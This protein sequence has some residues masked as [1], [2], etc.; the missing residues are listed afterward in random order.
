M[1]K[2]HLIAAFLI[3]AACTFKPEDDF[4]VKV[5]PNN[6][7]VTHFQFFDEDD[8]AMR[9]TVT[10]DFRGSSEDQIVGYKLFLN[11]TL[12]SE[13]EHPYIQT[14][15][16]RDFE[17]G[18]YTL[19][20]ILTKRSNSE[21][22]GSA[23]GLEFYE[24]KIIRE[25]TIYNAPIKAPEITFE[26]I[27]G[28]LHANVEPYTGHGFEEYVVRTSDTPNQSI[29]DQ[30]FQG[31]A[32]PD[33]VGGSISYSIWLHAYNEVV[34][35]TEYY[36]NT[37]NAQVI[38]TETGLKFTWN[39]SPFKNWNGVQIGILPQ[40]ASAYEM[41]TV[42]KS[43]TEFLIDM[44][45]VFPVNV[46]SYIS[47]QNTVNGNG[48]TLTGKRFSSTFLSFVQEADR[49]KKFIFQPSIDSAFTV[50]YP[51]N[52]LYEDL[53]IRYSHSSGEVSRINGTFAVS[54]NKKNVF[55]FHSNKIF[56]VDP[57]TLAIVDELEILPVVGT[58]NAFLQVHA[59]NS[60]IVLIY[61]TK[62]SEK[63]YYAFNWQTK[64]LLFSGTTKSDFPLVK[65]GQLSDDGTLFFRIGYANFIELINPNKIRGFSNIGP[66]S[67]VGSTK[68]IIIHYDNKLSLIECNPAQ[69][70]LTEIP[71]T[72]NVKAVFSNQTGQTAVAYTEAG[73][74]K[75]DFFNTETLEYLKSM[76]TR[77]G[78]SGTYE[79]FLTED[80]LVVKSS[81]FM[82]L[83]HYRI[84][85]DF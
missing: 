44:P 56:K 83:E 50:Y 35:V 8:L 64:S 27:D 78:A 21:S 13:G 34:E 81:G 84:R 61:I 31:Q 26:I 46:D 79:Y 25:A 30:N 36:Q 66:I 6:P 49:S 11:E 22:L 80:K 19:T 57:V 17:D 52:S 40:N 28:I 69:A 60:N 42:D 55:G 2:L 24:E 85:L 9:K 82:F 4:F 10:L 5:E 58:Y 63:W 32:I 38:Q 51:S 76:P 71:F 18:E 43:K 15:D 3:V 54:P 59:S 53:L 65:D 45:L 14:I 72:K 77:L 23:V 20:L 73:Y 29:T 39:A 37:L 41:H 1:R 68:K 12:I 75:I 7:T 48:H 62:A 67:V 47:T 70:L 74:I 16:S 33:F